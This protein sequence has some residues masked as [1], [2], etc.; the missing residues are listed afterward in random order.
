MSHR[1]ALIPPRI[2][3]LFTLSWLALTAACGTKQ[4]KPEDPLV[5]ETDKGLVRGT[6]EEELHVF[7]GIPYA[8]PPVGELRFQPPQPHS[9][10]TEVREA[11]A[12]GPACPQSG[13][14]IQQQ[15]AWS[16][17]C[18]TLNVWTHAD[19]KRRPVMVFIHGGGFIDGAGSE[20]LYE[21]SRLARAGDVVVVTLNYRLG[22]LGFMT[23]RALASA[24]SRGNLGI[25]DQIAALEWV[26]NN[27]AAFGG[28]PERVSLFGES[29][30]ASSVCAH[31]A[32][33]LSKGLFQRAI[34][35]SG[36][37][38]SGVLSPETPSPLIQMSALDFGARIVSHTPCANASD[39][40]ACL[41]QLPAQ[42][43]LDA[44]AALVRAHGPNAV[45]GFQ[46]LID[47]E[48]LSR[49]PLAAFADGSAHDV[50]LLIGSNANE[51]SLF[52][53]GGFD[54]APKSEQEYQGRLSA[55]FGPLAPA[56]LEAYPARDFPTPAH[57]YESLITDLTFTCPAERIAELAS[58]GEQPAFRYYF[59]HSMGGGLGQRLG[60]THMLEL[61]FVFDR[62]QSVP[63]GNQLAAS[64]TDAR[65]VSR[66]QKA[67]GSFAWEGKPA[68][69]PAWQATT[70][71]APSI[72]LLGEPSSVVTQLPGNR[73][74]KLR[75]MGLVR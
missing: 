50:P 60:A 40:V 51:W 10:W 44:V 5:I 27:I 13:L 75:S 26:Q 43:F 4:L 11:S 45:L 66:I 28:D 62:L 73:C 14:M 6:S 15:L 18:L 70:S 29:A 65:M 55:S 41:R 8:A 36:P 59:T 67:W 25:R 22:A 69:E 7:R 38:C 21:G 17:D 47:N 34:V 58:G 68:L 52:S 71:A 31:L 61:G 9:G 20:P 72:A 39:E 2:L 30:G 35:Q 64:D 74:A 1:P 53:L 33:P 19:G 57:A 49:D 16:E 3:G 37:G 23:T 54:Q 56:L 42:A 48:V 32:S 46:T 63:L 12:M 24:G